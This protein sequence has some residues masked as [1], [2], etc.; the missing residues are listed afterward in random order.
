MV[1][2]SAGRLKVFI[3]YS[4]RNV[5]F[6]D[7]LVVALEDR[8][9]E[10]VLDRHDIAEGERWEDRLG[11]LLLSA[12]AIV[13]VL[14]A[15]S[16][17]SEVCA[18]EAG[19]AQ[20]LGKRVLPVLLGPLGGV[21]VPPVLKS[22]NYI[23]FYTD[24][25]IPGSGAYEGLRRLERALN[26]DI[27]WIRDQTRLS[28]R[29]AEWRSAHNEDLLLRGHIL[30]EA[31]E[32]LERAPGGAVV[33]TELREYISASADAQVQRDAEAKAQL[34]EREQALRQAEAAM[35][36]KRAAER[37]FRRWSVGSLAAGVVLL[38]GAIAG[39]FF[40][41]QERLQAQAERAG[42]LAEAA[43]TLD[44]EGR[45]AQ[46]MLMSL[47]SE[48]TW[49]E[50]M[51][52]LHGPDDAIR[53]ARET[54][55]RSQG[56]NALLKTIETGQP[57][58]AM[59]VD[60][61]TGLV[62]TGHRD[63][64]V[65][66]WR[67]GEERPVKEFQGLD[68]R[69]TGVAFFPGD[70]V[71]LAHGAIGMV[72]V[73]SAA[74][75]ERLDVFPQDYREIMATIEG[76]GEDAR[77]TFEQL[78]E[79]REEQRSQERARSR[80]TSLQITSTAD[81]LEMS[82][83]GSALLAVSTAS[84]T[85]AVTF[86]AEGVVRYIVPGGDEYSI[87]LAAFDPNNA[88]RLITVSSDG[89]LALWQPP[90]GQTFGDIGMVELDEPIS[91]LS[92]TGISA[93]EMLP[94]GLLG[95]NL[96][97]LG[98]RDGTVKLVNVETGATRLTVRAHDAEILDIAT[99]PGEPMFL[100][101]AQDGSAALWRISELLIDEEG[102]D[103]VRQE[104]LLVGH[105][106][107]VRSVAFDTSS[108]RMLTGSR[109][110]TVKVWSLPAPGEVQDIATFEEIALFLDVGPGGH[111]IV[112]TD[113]A[114]QIIPASGEE[115]RRV[116]APD[117]PIFLLP[118]GERY[119]VADS[120]NAVRLMRVGAEGSLSAYSGHDDTVNSMAAF[121]DGE[122]FL[123]ASDD[124]TVKLWRLDRS[125]P[126]AT[127]LSPDSSAWNQSVAISPDQKNFVVGS[128]EGVVVWSVENAEA[129]LVTYR[130]HS[131]AT[132]WDVA[133]LGDDMVLSSDDDA[134]TR[135]WRVA[136]GETVASHA[137]SF[138]VVHP[139]GLHYVVT[140]GASAS[141]WSRGAT[142]ALEFF[143]PKESFIVAMGVAPYDAGRVLFLSESG[144]LRAWSPRTL[145]DASGGVDNRE[146]CAQ[147]AAIGLTQFDEADAR[148]FP[149][150]QGRLHA[151]CDRLFPN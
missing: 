11:K 141:L 32:W 27:E 84:E 109:D 117:G 133:F 61:A 16:A 81:S 19:E 135:L 29:A 6:A 28:E 108:G 55:G 95:S 75:G 102:A 86:D 73:Y 120:D 89:I 22:L 38:A 138:S 123:S 64:T 93:V 7:Q 116:A 65:K 124:G 31:H 137:A 85:F 113:E 24:P 140:D 35:T 100:T 132:V 76:G 45:H 5:T 101:G 131:D 90:E 68:L 14:T 96:A 66:L 99:Y 57:V 42:L 49:Q 60:P 92:E 142:Q 104:A 121:A 71:L 51:F 111:V 119:L 115:V 118:D 46:A 79:F 106:G 107:P 9:F 125:E 17:A 151:P 18:W 128:D 91:K 114:A 40:A 83:D 36:E 146:V 127:Y 37:R 59:A 30:H 34:V 62:L 54:L 144:K 136:D 97:L 72:L 105:D 69:V 74:T 39:G 20:R 77:E 12:D 3:S 78:V 53:A 56:S 13:F 112:Y 21:D 80:R 148:R 2:G 150:L 147:L 48:A 8:G 87:Q 70:R 47:L 103:A 26:T 126:L 149:I 58:E 10:P 25:E 41:V 98:Y 4:R 88:A 134:G 145:S 50:G 1:S 33:P 23:H 63:G 67:L 43:R 139:D 44:E 110:G 52:G 94:N 143:Q 122:R 129:P 82:S 130:G 15:E